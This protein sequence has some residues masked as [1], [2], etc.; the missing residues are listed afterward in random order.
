MKEVEEDEDEERSNSLMLSK[1]KVMERGAHLQLV[2]HRQ[3]SVPIW[4]STLVPRGWCSSSSL[5]YYSLPE[6]GG[7]KCV[8]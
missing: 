4:G 8:I 2:F 5:C 3:L 7:G 6:K 1:S